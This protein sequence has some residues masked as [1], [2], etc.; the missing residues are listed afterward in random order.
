MMIIYHLMILMIKSERDGDESN[1][2]GT[3]IA[4]K[5]K[6]KLPDMVE[7]IVS[8]TL[9]LEYIGISLDI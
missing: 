4:R 3:E 5:S 8:M 6:V 7:N 1:L 9:L 2:L